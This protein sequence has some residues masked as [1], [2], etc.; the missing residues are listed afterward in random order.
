MK[1]KQLHTND[2]EIIETMLSLNE[3]ETLIISDT[4]KEFL[5][6]EIDELPP[7]KENEINISAI[8]GFYND[9]N[10]EVKAYLR[11]GFKKPV[12]FE[13]MNVYILNEKNEILG[14]QTFNF[15][16]FGTI[17]KGMARPIKLYFDKCNIKVDDINKYNWKIGFN[18]EINV[19]INLK[20]DYS[21]ILKN[22]SVTDN[23]VIKKFIEEQPKMKLNSFSFSTFNIMLNT[24]GEIV[25]TVLVRNSMDKAIIINQVPMTIFNENDEL[26]TRLKFENTNLEIAKSSAIL[27]NFV[28]KTQLEIEQNIDCNNYKVIFKY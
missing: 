6:D 8:Y 11:N 27:T 21:S 13:E 17:D 9:N 12:N 20:L 15:K 23:E 3:R 16:T 4:Q 26:I 1:I 22:E 28:I 19:N 2:N 25:V 7:I 18:S 24:N 14:E 10:L 5:K